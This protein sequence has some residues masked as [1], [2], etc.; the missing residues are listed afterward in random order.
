MFLGHLYRLLDQV[1]FLEKGA[2]GT[3]AVETLL[4]SSFLHVFLWK[5]LKGLD[6]SPL[7]H[8]QARLLVDSCKGSYIPKRLPLVY[9]WSRRMQRKGQNFLELL[10][11]VENF[12]FCPHCALPEEFKHVPLYADTDGLVKASV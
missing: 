2:A 5:R 9:R 7:P 8:S 12:F 3:V 11:G 4:N 1:H 10:D 6:V